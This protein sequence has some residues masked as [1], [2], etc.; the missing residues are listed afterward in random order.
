[1]LVLSR[2]RGE[3]L[4]IDTGR[5]VLKVHIL[6]TNDRKGLVSLGIEAPKYIT[7]DREEVYLRRMGGPIKCDY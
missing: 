4:I 3:T 2:G 5:E 1:M 6:N 7:V